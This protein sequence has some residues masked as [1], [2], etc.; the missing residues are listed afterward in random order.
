M[1]LNIITVVKNDATGLKFTLES[2]TR[3]DAH[4]P[5]LIMDGGSTDSTLEVAAQ[6]SLSLP[7]QVRSEPDDGPYDAMNRAINLHSESDLIWFVNAGDALVG[8]QAISAALSL[9]AAKGFKW[10][11]GPH[12]VIEESGEFRRTVP[13]RPFSIWNFAY[14]RTPICHQA[15]IARASAL[16]E[17]GGFDLNFPIAADYRSLLLLGS[18][19]TPMQWKQVLVQYRAG[20]ISDRDLPATIREQGEIRRRVLAPG[21]VRMAFDHIYD[22]YRLT[23]HQI[24]SQLVPSIHR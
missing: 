15:V 6:F 17:V 9:T 8:N 5:L 24:R 2:V 23:R 16:R 11:F 1:G 3:Q 21:G 13:G 14:G 12:H 22:G 10:G 4:V 7:L 18:K 19:Y 20:G